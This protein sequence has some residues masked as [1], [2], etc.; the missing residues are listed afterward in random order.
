MVFDEGLG[1]GLAV[2]GLVLGDKVCVSELLLGL[3]ETDTLAMLL[4]IIF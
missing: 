3:I 2:I 1:L 4:S